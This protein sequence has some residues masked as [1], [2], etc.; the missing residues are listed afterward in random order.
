[1]GECRPEMPQ[2]TLQYEAHSALAAWLPAWLT[3]PLR[4]RGVFFSRY[5]RET[6]GHGSLLWG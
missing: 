3:R 4:S 1:M 5:L 6:G 2:N